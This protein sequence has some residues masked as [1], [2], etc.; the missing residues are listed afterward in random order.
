VQIK[1]SE[2]REKPVEDGVANVEEYNKL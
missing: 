2:E 1:G